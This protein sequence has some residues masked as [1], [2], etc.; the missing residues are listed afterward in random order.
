MTGQN[1]L[2]L[3]NQNVSQLISF[4]M[5]TESQHNK[6][7][8]AFLQKK[9]QSNFINQ[10][11]ILWV[12]QSNGFIMPVYICI[13]PFFERV[14]GLQFLAFIK[15][16]K[17]IKFEGCNLS[18]LQKSFYTIVTRDNGQV[19]NCSQSFANFYA[20]QHQHEIKNLEINLFEMSQD[21]YDFVQDLIEQ[22]Y[23]K[24]MVVKVD[25]RGQKLLKNFA[26]TIRTQIK[27]FFAINPRQLKFFTWLQNLKQ[28]FEIQL[29][30]LLISSKLLSFQNSILKCISIMA[31]SINE[32]QF[33]YQDS[34]TFINMKKLC[35]E[36]AVLKNSFRDY[37]TVANNESLNNIGVVSDKFS[38]LS[39]TLVNSLENIKFLANDVMNDD[40]FD[41]FAQTAKLKLN[42]KLLDS[43]GYISAIELSLYQAINQIYTDKVIEK[44]DKDASTVLELMIYLMTPGILIS[45]IAGS[46]FIYVML[47]LM[48]NRKKVIIV[49]GK[50]RQQT[51]I[52]SLANIEIGEKV[53]NSII[54]NRDLMDLNHNSQNLNTEV[55]QVQQ[56]QISQYQ[57]E[58]IN[59][60]DSIINM[61]VE[62][63]FYPNCQ[64]LKHH[65]NQN[66]KQE[67][68]E[69][70]TKDSR[71][72][73]V[74]RIIFYNIE[75]SFKQDRMGSVHFLGLSQEMQGGFAWDPQKWHIINFQSNY[76]SFSKLLNAVFKLQKK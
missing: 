57:D 67:P 9:S 21:I 68:E 61:T 19:M 23:L 56:E 25:K 1:I 59:Q 60:D 42:L 76:K 29:E 30:I 39:Q 36:L 37:I 16:I 34:N 66:Q 31:V 7:L 20:A 63:N 41:R 75:K 45:L 46:C 51:I 22:Q 28:V 48:M 2:R 58:T 10:A 73:R 8:E 35:G 15:K 52:D 40:H 74:K 43:N 33:L 14:N 4:D 72:R 26:F 71:R 54:N 47:R 13:Q 17:K 70:K 64:D 69:I 50:I 3:K 44:I 5:V 24:Q 55:K 49:L 65:V 11:Q 6:Y 38:Y 18:A 53:L 12:K 27:S 62:N 32:N